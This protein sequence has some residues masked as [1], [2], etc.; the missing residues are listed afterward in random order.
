MVKGTRLAVLPRLLFPRIHLSESVIF[1]DS[2]N[3]CYI[4]TMILTNHSHHII[5]NYK[6]LCLSVHPSV[7]ES[8]R[9][10]LSLI[11]SAPSQ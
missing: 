4:T 10:V 6:R 3:G 2:D 9:H 5:H 11:I 8:C 7:C 1:R